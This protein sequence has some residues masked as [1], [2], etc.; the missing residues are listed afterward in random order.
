[1]IWG[2]RSMRRNWISRLIRPPMSIDEILCLLMILTATRWPVK[3]CVAS[4][5]LPNVPEPKVW[6]STYNPIMRVSLPLRVAAAWWCLF[7]RRA[8]R[9]SFAPRS[10]DMLGDEALRTRSFAGDR[11]RDV[12]PHYIRR[13]NA[14]CQARMGREASRRKASRRARRW[15]SV[16]RDVCLASCARACHASGTS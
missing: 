11:S 13:A 9:C 1:M 10:T 7:S 15:V 14:S 3:A 6:C 2:W 4:L 8:C 12:P 16:E 5:T